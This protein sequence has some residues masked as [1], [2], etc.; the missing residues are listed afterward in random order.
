MVADGRAP[1]TWQD[2]S[3]H[4]TTHRG[5]TMSKKKQ[6]VIGALIHANGSHPASWL[7]QEAQA[8]ASTDV[9]YYRAMAQLP[10]RGQFDFF[11]IAH[12]P[13]APTQNLNAC[14]PPPQ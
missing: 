13:S 7:M 3:G 4:R 5:M 12:T 9:D 6:M 1:L 10:E 8:N 2:S 11:F 14:T